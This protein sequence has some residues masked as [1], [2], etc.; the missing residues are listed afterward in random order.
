MTTTTSIVAIRTSLGFLLKAAQKTW[1]TFEINWNN[2]LSMYTFFR[3]KKTRTNSF[4][5]DFKIGLIRLLGEYMSLIEVEN[6]TQVEE[7]KR[8]ELMELEIEVQDW[9]NQNI[10]QEVID[11]LTE[12]MEMEELPEDTELCYLYVVFNKD[13][14]CLSSQGPM[15]PDYFRGHSPEDYLVQVAIDKNSTPEELFNEMESSIEQW[16]T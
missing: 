13:G 8:K 3:I 12:D 15:L 5:D 14:V 10:T 11:E 9:F 4:N 2:P 7:K 16:Y 1:K 6:K